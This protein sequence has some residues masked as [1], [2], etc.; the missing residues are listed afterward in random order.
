LV[1]GLPGRVLVRIVGADGEPVADRAI[2]LE[3]PRLGGRLTATTDRDGVAVLEG[4]VG[5]PSADE[6]CGGPTAAAAELA[7]GGVR[8]TFCLAVDPDATLVVRAPPIEPS[9]RVRLEILRR[10]SVAR[11]PVVVDALVH[12]GDGWAPVAS[13][14][15]AA[16][17]S[18]LWLA[19][20]DDVAGEVWLRAR[21]VLEG[22][23][24]VRGGGV[25]AWVGPAP[26]GVALVAD[27]RSARVEGAA[28]SDTLAVFALEPERADALL[29]SLAR[30][31]GPVGAAIDA[32][33]SEARVRML[34]ATRT[35]RDEAVS[36]VLRE[37]EIVVLPLPDRPAELGLL[38]DPWRTRARF[39]R[40]RI[41]RIMRAVESYVAFSVPGALEEVAVREARGHRF[42]AAI[43]EA[44]LSHAG[45]GGEN[46]T[47][48]DGEPL[49]VAALRAMDPAFTYDNVARRITRERL[50]RAAWMLRQLVRDRQLD[51]PWARRGD[52][53][54][55][56]A[57]ML[58]ADDVEWE[59]APE[60][61]HLFDAWGR[62]F[63]LRPARGRARF[64]FLEPVPGWEIVSAG[65]DGRFG[66]GDDLADPFARVLPSGGLYAEA[67]GEDEL[68]AR[69]NGVALGRAT[70]ET[71]GELFEVP[72]LEH[73]EEHD[74]T[75]ALGSAP[76]RLR[77]SEIGPV[78]VAPPLDALGAV[79]PAGNG[80]RT[81]TLPP[82]RRRHSAV[83]IRFSASVPPS[84]ARTELV[85]G[86]PYA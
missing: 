33:A 59:E 50:W 65:P 11:R 76:P 43:L 40:G 23:R 46:A 52:P 39:V 58:E 31:L 42:N 62:P 37:G 38:R 51:L 79:G 8:E 17:E 35:P 75:I 25:L 81:W 78:A 84:S 27:A 49:D 64:T 86:A 69:L 77:P 6:D 14:S 63:A 20:P 71:L 66:T 82:E 73:A 36:A 56:L 44:A 26:R 61:S 72:E 34:L 15:L 47:A 83:A 10:S 60:R 85:A 80:A 3:M 41:G 4:I 55:Y 24:Q 30:V 67:V 12:A 13:A 68:L 57:A 1:P 21:P 16:G 53:A 19:L 70:A 22:S 29:A 28:G 7:V 9:R 54:Q 2:A 18:R 48:L 45:L 5:E 32:A 74:V